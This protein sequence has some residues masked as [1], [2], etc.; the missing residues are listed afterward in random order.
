M[1]DEQN[2]PL[3]IVRPGW[4]FY[5]ITVLSHWC[6]KIS[7]L[8]HV[9]KN[10]SGVKFF[11]EHPVS[12]SNLLEVD[13]TL[14]MLAYPRVVG[15]YEHS[16]SNPRSNIKVLLN[17]RKSLFLCNHH[18]MKSLSSSNWIAC[19]CRSNHPSCHLKNIVSTSKY[20]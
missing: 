19:S 17:G 5:H 12:Y 18:A 10:V 7:L 3:S 14:T 11:F 20:N 8:R 2:W 13:Q 15:V 9:V 1:P 16:K 6:E 4:K